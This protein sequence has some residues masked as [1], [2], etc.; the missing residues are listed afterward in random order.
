MELYIAKGII[1]VVVCM[2]IFVMISEKSNSTMAVGAVAPN[3]GVRSVHGPAS[4]KG[5]NAHTTS[6]VPI[7]R[8]SI[9]QQVQNGDK[10]G[11]NY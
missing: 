9:Q 5:L 10:S 2:E 6:Q 1:K 4:S 3:G 8:H 7:L 11:N